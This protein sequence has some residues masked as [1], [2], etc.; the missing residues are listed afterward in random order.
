MNYKIIFLLFIVTACC[1]SQRSIG[2]VSK[3]QDVASSD[4]IDVPVENWVGKKFI[5]LEKN[6]RLQE[7]GYDLHLNKNFYS[8]RDSYDSDLEVNTTY[9]LKYSRFVGKTITV[10]NV[11]EGT[12]GNIY[13]FEE[14]STG[15]KLY[16]QPYNGH[17]DG[18]APLLDIDRAKKR[19]MGKTLYSKEREINTYDEETGEYGTVKVKIGIPLKVIDIWW[20][21]DSVWP[22]WIIVE[23]KTGEKGYIN[24]KFSWTN[25]YSDWWT[26]ARPWE[27]DFFEF[28]P[29][30]KYKWSNDVWELI[31]K[32]KVKIG[33]T[34]E[35]IILS[36]GKPKEMNKDIY[37]SGTHEQW[38]YEG[39][40][41]Y[42]ENGKLTSM[43]NRK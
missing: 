22:I 38:I 32:Q 23:T 8:Y 15:L 16:G 36:W 24:T 17:I 25:V 26:D 28:N 42:L 29:K 9:N 2:K 13:V 35:Q 34:K 14:D 3:K 40:Y 41:L 37:K 5:F 43:Q 39:Q 30:Q 12:V 31:D 33:M 6:K 11:E 18:I 4:S 19:W 27:D 10:V 21:L 20:G 1:F 7:F